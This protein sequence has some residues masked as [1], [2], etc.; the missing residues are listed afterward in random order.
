ME[1][2]PPQ[3][4]QPL[5]PRDLGLAHPEAVADLFSKFEDLLDCGLHN[6][7]N[8]ITSDIKRDLQTLGSRIE[9]MENKLDSS[10]S[11]T[12]QNTD[13]I[14]DLQ[15]QL[16]TAMAKIDDLENRNR[17]YNFRIR[18]LLETFKDVPETIHSLS[19][20]LIFHSTDWS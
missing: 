2:G 4:Q 9:V 18:G 20:F 11:R 5:Q 6:T 15:N 12:N 19:C 10:I 17:R 7:A 3:T 14:Q 1:A 13:R 16:E 8:K